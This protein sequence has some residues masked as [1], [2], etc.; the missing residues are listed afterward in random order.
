MKK[1]FYF[2]SFCL[3]FF[4]VPAIS[5]TTGAWVPSDSE[6]ELE[7]T[8]NEAADLAA[9]EAAAA[10]AEAKAAL[11]PVQKELNEKQMRLRTEQ[12]VVPLTQDTAQIEAIQKQGFVLAKEIMWEEFEEQTDTIRTLHTESQEDLTQE[13]QD[14]SQFISAEKLVAISQTPHLARPDYARLTEGKKFIYI[15]ESSG[16]NTRTLPREGARILEEIYQANLPNTRILLALEMATLT[17]QFASPLLPSQ[18]EQSTANIDIYADYRVLADTAHKKGIDVLALDDSA[19]FAT[20]FA[21]TF[22]AK[23]GAYAIRFRPD[24]SK[25]QRLIA[26]YKNAYN[27]SEFSPVAAV[28]DLLSRSSWGMQQRNDQWVRYIQSIADLYDIIIVY[29]GN[30]HLLLNVGYS[31]PNLIGE[32]G[33]LLELLTTEQLSQEVQQFADKAQEVQGKH[34]LSPEFQPSK[35]TTYEGKLLAAKISQLK[36]FLKK[37]RKGESF[38]VEHATNKELQVGILSQVPRKD[39]AKYKKKLTGILPDDFKWAAVYLPPAQ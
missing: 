14:L 8:L 36:P 21:D 34:Q 2:L 16:H 12:R 27:E 23:L 5:Q 24:T 17:N 28:Y 9:K 38:W 35:L 33:I 39:Y 19:I 18:S 30:A 7:T 3:L 6:Q 4:V 11:P 29:A 32:D 26:P 10:K 1:F 25:V 15:A 31:V 22:I 37:L 13:E 20:Q